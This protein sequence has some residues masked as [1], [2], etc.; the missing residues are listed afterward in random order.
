MK[1]ADVF[2]METRT[3]EEASVRARVK[4]PHIMALKRRF[5]RKNVCW[6]SA[7]IEGEVAAL[8]RTPRIMNSTNLF[9]GP[10]LN[11]P[12]IAC[13]HDVVSSVVVLEKGLVGGTYLFEDG[14]RTVWRTR[15]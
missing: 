5:R 8:A 1:L 15:R 6:W 10:R 4:R 9:S 13:D 11:A 3:V 2:M 14:R 12:E 7:D